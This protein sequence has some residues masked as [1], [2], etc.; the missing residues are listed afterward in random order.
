MINKRVA[1]YLND[2]L[3][4]AVAA[5]RLLES[6]EEVYEEL[7][8][9]LSALRA[10]IEADRLD[11]QALMARLDIGESQARKIGGWVAEQATALK[12]RLDDSADGPLRLFE[13]LEFLSLGIA[14][15]LGLWEALKA[16]AEV[17]PQLRCADYNRLIQRAIEQRQPRRDSQAGSRSRGARQ[18]R[19][20]DGGDLNHSL[21]RSGLSMR[22]I[23]RLGFR[24]AFLAQKN[25]QDHH[26]SDRQEFTLPVLQG[27]KPET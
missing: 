10:D 19:L 7:R 15:K 11:L 9:R 26:R 6:L 2:H 25:R 18:K 12:M 21:I 13:S 8:P 27:L 23:N 17:S 16:A 3:A 14:G 24:R 5:V 22:A 4:G 1:T 20:V